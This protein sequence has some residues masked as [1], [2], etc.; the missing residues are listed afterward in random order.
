MSVR[1]HVSMHE[2]RRPIIA[3][4]VLVA[5]L[6]SCGRAAQTSDKHVKAKAETPM[7]QPKLGE[8]GPRTFR[9]GDMAVYPG[10]GLVRVEGHQEHGGNPFLMLTVPDSGTT[11]GVPVAKIHEL[12]RAPVSRAEAERLLT[13]LRTGDAGP[14]D[15]RAWPY[16]FRDFQRALVKGSLEDQVRALHRLCVSRYALS[17]GERQLIMTFEDVI[18][19]ELAHVVGGTKDALVDEL[20]GMHPAFSASAPERPPEQPIAR[21]TPTPPIK[22]AKHEYLGE[23]TV[24]DGRLVVGEFTESSGDS[25]PDAEERTSFVS[26]AVPGAWHAFVRGDDEVEALIAVHRDHADRFKKL[27]KSAV[28]LSRVIV[29][30]GRMTFLDAAVRDDP[31]YVD[32]AMFPLFGD[33]LILDRGCHSGTGGDGVDTVRGVL[34]DGKLV[35]V[36][37]SFVEE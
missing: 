35:F 10:M 16:R 5:A 37:V 24:A 29:N 27:A 20:H 21:P 3:V 28:P 17:F 31:K 2:R 30:G 1:L 9:P 23:F 19:S 14:P 12:L 36:S 18:L 4:A 13:I 33:G 25:P 7:E 15:D 26:P 32:E 22:L 6:A 34:V 8:A 11:V